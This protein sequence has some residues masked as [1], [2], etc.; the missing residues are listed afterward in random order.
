MLQRNKITH[1][2]LHAPVTT[3]YSSCT[4]SMSVLLT[5][6][7]EIKI[8]EVKDKGKVHPRT[9]H[10]G[11]KGEWGYSSTLSLISALDGGGWSMP[12][13]GRFTPQKISNV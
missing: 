10:K 5:D 6:N 4:K 9:G 12:R 7:T 11:P 1:T 13:P 2:V 8:K 3:F